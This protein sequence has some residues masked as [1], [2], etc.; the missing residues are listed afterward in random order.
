M[1]GK[2]EI[3]KKLESSVNESSV[4]SLIDVFFNMMESIYCT[5]ETNAHDAKEKIDNLER[6][7]I[8]DFL[9]RDENV[10]Y[11][12]YYFCKDFKHL[13]TNKMT[14]SFDE[15]KIVDNGL[16]LYLCGVEVGYFN[17]TGMDW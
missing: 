11:S 13:T 12:V 17:L 2:E 4:D 1:K 14:L 9:D 6:G 3:L 7:A 16:N 5:E 15:C 10:I 8:L